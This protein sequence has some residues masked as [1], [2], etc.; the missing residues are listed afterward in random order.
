MKNSENNYHLNLV[1]SEEEQNLNLF[2]SQFD[3]CCGYQ[4]INI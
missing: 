1:L 3:P 2:N 4:I